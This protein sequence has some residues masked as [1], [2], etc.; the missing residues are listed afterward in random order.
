MSIL[1]KNEVLKFEV[2]LSLTPFSVKRKSL[3]VFKILDDLEIALGQSETLLH[4]RHVTMMIYKQ[5]HCP[6]YSVII[7]QKRTSGCCIS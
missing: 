6:I 4:R 2:G 1:Y 5:F 3:F 7:V